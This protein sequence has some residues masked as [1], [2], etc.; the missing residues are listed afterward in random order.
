MNFYFQNSIF[1]QPL[2]NRLN[3]SPS[4]YL[5]AHGSDP[6]AWQ[7][8]NPATLELARKENKL[9]FVSIGYFSCHWCH[10]MQAESYRNPDIAALI[11]NNFIPVKVDRE[12]DVALDA[13]MIAYAQSTLGTAGWPL[14]VF[15]TPEGY[16]LYATLYEPPVRFKLMLNSLGTEWLKDSAGLKAIA[17]NAVKK[18]PAG[19]KIKPTAALANKYRTQLVQEALEQ[20]DFLSGGLNVPRKFP[21][22]PQLTALLEIEAHEHD[23]KLAEWLDLTLD[24]MAEGGLRDQLSGGFFRYTVDPGWQKPHFEK[25]L[26]DNAQLA[27]IY[28]RAAAILKKPAYRDIAID[29]LDFMLKDMRVGSGFITSISAVDEQGK[30]GG[31]YLWT[32]AQLKT[33]L[34]PDEYQLVHKVWGMSAASE[35]E[36]GYLPQYRIVPSADELKRLQGINLKLQQQLDSRVVPKD[37][38]LL[39]GLNGMMLETL[40]EAAELSPRYRQAADELGAFM[41]K[42]LWQNE[43]LYKGISKQQ[44]LGQ[45][46]LE[47]YAYTASGLMRYAQLS[48]KKADRS[49]VLQMQELAWQ[50][51]HTPNGFLLEQGSELATP[52]HQV[53]IEDGPLPSPSAVLIKTSLESGDKVLRQN[54]IDALAYGDVVLQSGVFWFSTQVM[55]LNRLF[56]THTKH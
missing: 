50:K 22:S 2:E 11:N 54:A 51:F 49:I 41:L 17:K 15:I 5:A 30:E 35:F 3:D 32:E 43:V 37:T 56:Q 18:V 13:E 4:P 23:A 34:D 39:A 24:K 16:P 1:A 45:G 9:L 6:V 46:D 38:K 44:L 47:A 21:L 8:W 48:G 55:A 28:L 25:M 26:Y 19:V 52:Y 29:T 20:A 7:E 10:V 14:N 12:I 27:I 33:V 42:Q 31:S 53:A 40:S 36:D